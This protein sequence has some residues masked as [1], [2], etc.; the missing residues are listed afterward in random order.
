MERIAK[1]EGR[2]S[3]KRPRSDRT[4]VEEIWQKR[5][6]SAAL[7]QPPSRRASKCSQITE[8]HLGKKLRSPLPPAPRSIHTLS[9]PAPTSVGHRTGARR[10]RKWRTDR[11]RGSPPCRVTSLT[12]TTMFVIRDPDDADLDDGQLVTHV[13][14]SYLPRA[15]SSKLHKKAIR[16][17]HPR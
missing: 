7:K 10:A 14:G 3:G 2:S 11:N 12:P 13:V 9:I 4:A 15:D 16:I 6:R 1:G 17:G 8:D 5:N